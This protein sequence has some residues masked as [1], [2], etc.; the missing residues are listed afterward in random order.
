MEP[1]KRKSSAR[2]RATLADVARL[3]GVSEITVSRVIRNRGPLAEKTRE[4]VLSVVA[5]LGYVPNR[6]AGTLAT[7]GSRLVGIII[8]SLSNIV[9]PEVL[10]GASGVLEPAGFQFVVGV[11]DYDLA[12]EEK[13]I[14]SLLAWQPQGLMVPGLEHSDT[15]RRLLTSAGIPIVELFDIDG[16]GIDNL[17]G[18]SNREAGRVAARHLLGRGYRRLGYVGHDFEADRRAFKRYEGFWSELAGVGRKVIGQDIAKGPSSVEAGRDGLARL[19]ERVPDLEAVYFSNDDMAIG[20]YF[21]CLARGIAVP[22]RLALF[23]HNGL[24]VGRALPQPLS[25]IRTPRARMGEEAARLLLAGEAAAV[26]DLGFVLVE[27]ATT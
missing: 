7:A 15:A 10:K 8:P 25:T 21:L 19:L 23:G 11:T 18:I 20:G 2:R 13:L 12:R 22:Q 14:A 26:R 24:D 6:A 17:V 3:A 1:T 27:G 9:F 5:Q 4:K 16:P